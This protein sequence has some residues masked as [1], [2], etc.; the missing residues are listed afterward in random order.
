MMLQ[1]FTW[2]EFLI[3]ALVLSVLWYAG[4]GLLF[5]R[6]EILGFLSGR[7]K[8][9]EP[10]AHSW[11]DQVDELELDLMGGVAGESG[12]SVLEADEFSFVPRESVDRDL[13]PLGDLADVQ[14]EIKGICSVL[15]MENGTRADFFALFAMIREKYPKV[16][17]GGVRV[18]LAEFIVEH[19]PFELS[20]DELAGL[21]D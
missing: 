13:D 19:L 15:E 5:Y 2:Q 7:G 18:E 12:V 14:D 4:V 8:S 9:S 1:V 10:L 16:F 20:E 17:E 11:Q 21:L 3:A 6:G